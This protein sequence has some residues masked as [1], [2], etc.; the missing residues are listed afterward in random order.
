MA[1]SQVMTAVTLSVPPGREAELVAGF[2]ELVSD[3]PRLDGLLRSELL[4]TSGG[5]WVIQ[6]LWRDRE[7]ILAVRQSGAAPLALVLAERIGAEH[8]HDVL[9]LEAALA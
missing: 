5:Q 9:T 1:S 8:S 6:T 2:R 3:G 7:A 4:R